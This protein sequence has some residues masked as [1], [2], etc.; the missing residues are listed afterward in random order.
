[1]ILRRATSAGPTL[2]GRRSFS[3]AHAVHPVPHDDV[4]LLG[5]DVDV[6]RAREIGVLDD[7]VAKLDDRARLLV[8]VGLRDD[9]P[10]LRAPVFR[11]DLLD[12]VVEAR[13]AVARLAE[14]LLD[15]LLARQQADHALARHL[16][17][18]RGKRDLE[19]VREGDE[20]QVAD[21][22]DR[23]DEV[24]LAELLRDPLERRGRDLVAGDVE[25]GQAE[26]PALRDEAL[27]GGDLVV[28]L[29]E[30]VERVAVQVLRAGGD[31][32]ALLRRQPAHGD[33]LG[34]DEGL[35]FAEG[36]G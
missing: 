35:D 14:L 19:R 4:L 11:A 33:E 9:V 24:L 2:T 15:V 34:D 31:R 27:E 12:D 8:D 20:E 30:A 32:V 22:P 17:D 6:A 28:L 25:R 18:L 16:L 1:M 23:Q 7:P 3:C 13:G 5:L 36:H 26:R 29:E 21:L 10:R